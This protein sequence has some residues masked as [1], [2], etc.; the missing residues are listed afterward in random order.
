MKNLVIFLTLSIFSAKGQETITFSQS[1][2]DRIIFNKIWCITSIDNDDGAQDGK[3]LIISDCSFIFG[4]DD[5]IF[6]IDDNLGKTYLHNGIRLNAK[7]RGKSAIVEIFILPEY[8]HPHTKDNLDLGWGIDNSFSYVKCRFN[9]KEEG[10][11][12]ISGILQSTSSLYCMT[13]VLNFPPQNWNGNF[14]S[15][16]E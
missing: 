14:S 10:S 5:R 12:T 3:W 16:G 8:R 15:S 1:E 6:S 11:E 7:L 9:Y 2:I 4:E 13:C